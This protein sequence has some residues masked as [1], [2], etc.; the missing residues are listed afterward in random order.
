MQ[1]QTTMFLNGRKATVVYY[2]DPADP[3]DFY[4]PPMAENAQITHIIV[5]GIN[6]AGDYTED[7][8]RELERELIG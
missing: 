3:G 5:D 2:Y 6:R 7:E 8:L 1:E 4:Q